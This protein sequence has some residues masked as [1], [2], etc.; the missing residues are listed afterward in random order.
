MSTSIFSNIL[1]ETK[2][3]YK[4]LVKRNDVINDNDQK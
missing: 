4:A 1:S 3:I 2:S